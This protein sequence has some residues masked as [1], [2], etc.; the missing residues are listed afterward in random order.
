MIVETGLEGAVTEKDFQSRKEYELYCIRHSAAHVMAEA[1]LRLRPDAKFTVGPPVEDGFYY[2][3]ETESP[4]S[5]EELPAIEAEMKKICKEGHSFQCE[6]WSRDQA[7]TF[8]VAEG[9]PH[10]LT[11]MSDREL[12]ECSIFRHSSFVDLCRGPHVDSTKKIKYFKLTSVS[13]AHWKEGMV[14]RIYGTAWQ[15]KGELKAYLGRLE[16]AARRDH[17]RLGKELDLFAFFPFSPGSPCLLP[18]G[19]VLYRILQEKMRRLLASNGYEEVRAPVLCHQSLWE[20]SGH[21]SKFREN[22]FLVEA[23][24]ETSGQYGLK[25]MNCPIHMKIFGLKKRSYRDLPLRIH[26]EGILHRNEVSGSLS[27]MTRVRMFC[28]DDTHIFVAPEEIQEEIGRVLA[29]VD[30]V[31]RAFGLTYHL[32]LST[33]PENYL[34]EQDQ[35]D[36]AESA[37]SKALESW[38]KPFAINEGDGAFYGPKIDFSVEDAIGRRW[39][40]GTAQLDFQL[41][42]PDRFN[43]RYIDEDNTP[44]HP[45]VIHQATYGSMERFLGILI[46]S[47]AGAFPVWLSPVQVRILTISEKFS[48]YAQQVHESIRSRGYRVELDLR[49][50]KIGKKIRESQLQKIPYTLVIGAKEAEE[51]TVAVRRYGEGDQGAQPLASFLDKFESEANLEY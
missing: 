9:Q 26:D 19:L 7:E 28:Q 17:R 12:T 27:G 32:E 51:S 4:I 46:E 39:Q 38:G 10:K 24:S 29:I 30:R 43:L 5:E 16:E 36:Q 21:W 40:V 34:G 15:S 25:P 44:R 33:R 11:I 3:F 49:N 42:G 37:L 50:D 14:Q 1:I 23:E 41:P 20:T 13:G 35:W 48:E 47:Y 45:V 6:M 2:D 22:M 18:K 31:Y 8:F